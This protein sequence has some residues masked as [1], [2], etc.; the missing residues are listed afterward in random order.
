[1][2]GKATG[3]G[4]GKAGRPAARPTADGPLPSALNGHSASNS[5][6]TAPGSP[7]SA[8]A[9]N[10]VECAGLVSRL[11]RA[12]GLAFSK[13]PAPTPVT[14]WSRVICT[15]SAHRSTRRSVSTRAAGSV[16]AGSAVCASP[17]AT[18][19][20]TTPATTTR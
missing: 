16:P 11:A 10:Q 2:E 20:A 7:Y 19:T 1:G 18:V 4:G 12:V 13:P 6:S 3:G 15:A 5:R 14:G 9:C 8:A 17:S